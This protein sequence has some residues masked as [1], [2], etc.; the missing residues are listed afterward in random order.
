MPLPN[1]QKRTYFAN[2]GDF[3][4]LL[5]SL[6]PDPWLR[7]PP[8]PPTPFLL[9]SFVHIFPFYLLVPPPPP[10]TY[11]HGNVNTHI[12]FLT[13]FSSSVNSQPSFI[14]D[15]LAPPATPSDNLLVL[16]CNSAP[17]T[18]TSRPSLDPRPLP[19]SPSYLDHCSP[20]PRLSSSATL[21]PRLPLHPSSHLPTDPG[22]V[23]RFPSSSNLSL[24]P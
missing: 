1:Q 12:T 4:G 24:P 3:T 16:L 7:R 19:T 10:R 23:T 17:S 14:P 22:I 8:L 5:H 9:L 18:Q 20:T 2:R 11:T 13:Y 6:E 15:F 21:Y